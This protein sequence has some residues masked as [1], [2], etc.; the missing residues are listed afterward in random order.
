MDVTPN[1]FT[2]CLHCHGRFHSCGVKNTI[3]TNTT[4]EID[5]DEVEVVDDVEIEQAEDPAKEEQETI[6]KMKMDEIKTALKSQIEQDEEDEEI[7]LEFIDNMMRRSDAQ[8]EEGQEV[9][10]PSFDADQVDYDRDSQAPEIEEVIDEVD[11]IYR[12]TTEFPKF[13]QGD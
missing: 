9:Y 8:K 12:I 3:A 11:A 7:S 2:M 4:I 13:R 5:D 6:N 1:I 10:T